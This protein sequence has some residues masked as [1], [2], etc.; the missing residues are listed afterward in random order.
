MQML[1]QLLWGDG[2]LSPGGAAEVAH[3]L[4]GSDIAGWPAH[5]KARKP[6][7]AD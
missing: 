5:F 2:F 4:E 7:S 6:V 1:L 3:L